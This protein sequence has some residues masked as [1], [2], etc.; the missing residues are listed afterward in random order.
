MDLMEEIY[1][2]TDSFPVWE[3]FG[4]SAQMRRCAVSVSS[5]V[6][7]GSR[8]GTRKEYAR[9]ISIAYGSCGELETQLEMAL[10]LRYATL[11]RSLL[12]RQ[13]IEDVSKMLNKLR[14]SLQS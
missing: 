12:A 14:Q 11:D 9:F 2:I 6:A 10:R 8:R 4:L 5:N 1:K 3:Q 13:L 7:E